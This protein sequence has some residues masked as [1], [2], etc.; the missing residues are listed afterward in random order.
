MSRK[1]LIKNCKVYNSLDNGQLKDILIEDGIILQIRKSPSSENSAQEVLDAGGRLVVPGFIDVHMQGA[2]GA[3]V[4]DGTVA[5]LRTISRTCARFGT[6]GF[7]A[8]TVFRPQ[9]DNHHITVAAENVG[10]GLGGAHLL[11]I[12]LEGPFIALEK[13]GMI[14]PE[15]VASPSKVLYNEIKEMTKGTLRMMTIAPELDGSLEIITDLKHSE[16][17]ASFGHSQASYEETV[18]GIDAG[19]SHATHLFNAMPALHHRAPGPLLAIFEAKNVSAQ[20]IP[21]GVHLHPGVLKLAFD[22]LGSCRCVTITDGMQAMGL[23]EGKYIYNGMEYEAKE[24][25]ARYHD[26]T[27]IGTALGLSQL[28]SRLMKFTQCNL[29]DAVRTVTENPAVLLGLKDK[30]GTI[31]MG[32]DADIVI[33]E[34]DFSVWVTIAG[35]EVVFR[36]G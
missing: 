17:V 3:D 1:T 6:T 31:E 24:G 32:K 20:I 2:G 22:L 26:G 12:H 18:Q 11:G 9:G 29:V 13:R 4:L 36:K 5:S 7:L 35:G 25:S 23:P 28:V 10:E 21:D 15:C 14:L 8:T 33:L 27:L 16:I 19:I 34:E 30:K